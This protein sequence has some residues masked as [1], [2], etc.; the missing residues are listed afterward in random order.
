MQQMPERNERLDEMNE[1][2]N[3]VIWMDIVVSII[4]V[5]G[6]WLTFFL[7]IRAL[8]L[9]WG[10]YRKEDHLDTNKSE[11]DSDFREMK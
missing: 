6:F 9:L 11:W 7:L 5:A 10:T 3:W 4:I 2:P 8:P 1:I